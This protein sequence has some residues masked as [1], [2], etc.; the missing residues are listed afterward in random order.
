MFVKDVKNAVEREDIW[1]VRKRM[2]KDSHF[3]YVIAATF[4]SLSTIISFFILLL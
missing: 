1:R 4:S 3:S 2:F